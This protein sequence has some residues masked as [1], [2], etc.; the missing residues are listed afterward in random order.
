MSVKIFCDKEECGKVVDQSEGGGTLIVVMK[1]S[2]LDPNT[3][4]LVPSIDQ[5]EYHLCA[6]HV[7]EVVDY[8]K[9]VEKK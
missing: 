3:K 8:L 2:K 9:K 1:I 5:E 4:E 6:E 7:K